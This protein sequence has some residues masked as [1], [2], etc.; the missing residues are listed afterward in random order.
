VEILWNHHVSDF[1]EEYHVPP[2]LHHDEAFVR[3]LSATHLP[4]KEIQ[5]ILDK[6]EK[7]TVKVCHN[8]FA[9]SFNEFYYSVIYPYF[10]TNISVLILPCMK[11]KYQHFS[12]SQG[13]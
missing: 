5:D 7:L 12:K 6:W 2:E 13:H 9:L 8:S 3:Y 1:E 4:K 10:S 11:S